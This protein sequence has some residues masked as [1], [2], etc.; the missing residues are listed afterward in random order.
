MCARL[1]ENKIGICY[2]ATLQHYPHAVDPVEPV[3][4]VDLIDSREDVILRLRPHFRLCDAVRF[5]AGGNRLC[6]SAAE[7]VSAPRSNTVQTRI[8]QVRFELRF[9]FCN[10]KS[11]PLRF[12]TD[13]CIHASLLTK[14]SKNIFQ[15]ALESLI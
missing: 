2:P 14:K 7:S 11:I 13:M 10:C 3:D 12:W 6:D 5:I 8:N 9:C 4:R 1:L 15:R